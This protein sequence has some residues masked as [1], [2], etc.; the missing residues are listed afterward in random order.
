M[1]KMNQCK[2]QSFLLPIAYRNRIGN[3]KA[4][5]VLSH[6]YHDVEIES[7]IK[8]LDTKVLRNSIPIHS[9]DTYN[10]ELIQKSI[11]AL[12]NAAG[13]KGYAFAEVHPRFRTPFKNTFLVGTLAGVV[14]ALTPI[15][16]I[17]KMVNIG[18]LLAFVIVCIAIM[19]LRRTDPDR[20]RPFRT[21]WVPLV[22]ILGIISCG[23]LM[24]SLPSDTW[25]RLIVWMA[26]G[27]VIY[28]L[29]GKS[30]SKLGRSEKIGA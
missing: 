13:T 28:F 22:P 26:I 12:T 2:C 9:G 24:A 8:E 27:L 15:D 21:P 7:N 5:Q 17:G 6:H 1:I 23:A 19:I 11:D 3:R 10:A 29:Y 14:G 18:T 16:D 25:I 20:P 30:H 4:H